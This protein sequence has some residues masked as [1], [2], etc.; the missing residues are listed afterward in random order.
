MRRMPASEASPP[1]I[2]L[3]ISRSLKIGGDFFPT[4]TSTKLR[5]RADCRRLGN[6]SVFLFAIWL[7]RA[8]LA[9]F[10]DIN[11]ALE[12]CAVFDGDA[13]R[14]NITGE[15]TIAADI[16][17]IAGGKIAAHFA[18]D[19]DFTRVDVGRD[20]TIAADGD[21]IAG[22]AD[23]AFDAAI[24][25]ERL[26]SSHLALDHQRLADGSLVRGSGG[27]GGRRT[28]RS[29]RLV[30][31]HCRRARGMNNRT[32]LRLSGTSG[33]LRLIRRLPH[34]LHSSFPCWD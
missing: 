15:G 13:G 14:D 18:E 9:T 17:A 26:R 25:V 23:G 4:Q 27:S 30:R 24:D 31:H 32:L 2:F 5:S 21:A 6:G 20:Y 19:H 1:P 29:G 34:G 22:Q 3:K 7:L 33:G 11:S 16:D 10:A 28:R 8:A 12:E